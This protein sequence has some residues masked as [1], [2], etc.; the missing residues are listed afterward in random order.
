[1]SERTDMNA[2]PVTASRAFPE[3]TLIGTAKKAKR[4]CALALGTRAD[5]GHKVS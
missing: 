1:V 5:P 2:Q 3:Y 4:T